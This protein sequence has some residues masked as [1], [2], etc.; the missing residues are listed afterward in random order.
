M[1]DSST[2][3]HTAFAHVTRRVVRNSEDWYKRSKFND[4]VRKCVKCDAR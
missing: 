1:S 4:R 3:T 2:P